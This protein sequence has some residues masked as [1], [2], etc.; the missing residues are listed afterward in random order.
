MGRFFQ[1]FWGRGRDFQELGKR[2]WAFMVGLC[3]VMAPV[4]MLFSMLIYYSEGIMRLKV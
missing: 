4:G 1:L 2:F 3:T